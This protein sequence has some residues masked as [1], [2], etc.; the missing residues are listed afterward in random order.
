MLKTWIG[1]ILTSLFSMI[2]QSVAPY[3]VKGL[4]KNIKNTVCKL[5]KNGLAY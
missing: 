4:L 5:I 2:I 3:N 1:L